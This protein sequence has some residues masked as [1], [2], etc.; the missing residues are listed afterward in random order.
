[1]TDLTPQ[2]EAALAAANVRFFFALRVDLP[3]YTLRL[4]DGASE[5]PDWI[6]PGAKFVGQDETFGVMDI[7]DTVADGLGDQAPTMTFGLTPPD[8][9]ATAL[10]A[11]PAMQGSR[12]RLWLG[13][14]LDDGSVVPSPHLCF[15]GELDVP[16]LSVGKGTRDISFDCVS[17]FERFF[18]DEEGARLNFANQR[19]FYPDDAG[20]DDVTGITRALLWGPGKQIAGAP[21]GGNYEGGF[22]GSRGGKSFAE[23]A[24]GREF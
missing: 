19:F 17:Q 12:T 20:L 5:V 13:A 11:N 23:S 4:L 14:L 22:G 1:M 6:N 16:T 15:D 9:A 18:R 10:L 7:P 3:G 24:F 21:S 8:E 2:M